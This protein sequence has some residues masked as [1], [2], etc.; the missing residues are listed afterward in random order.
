MAS[1]KTLYLITARG[2]SKGLPG[3]N[4]KEL[5]GKPLVAWSIEQAQNSRFA[6]DVIVSTDSEEI[7]EICREYGAEVPFLRP[8]QLASDEASSIDVVL[9]AIEFLEGIGR[10]YDLIGL[11]EPTSPLRDSE[12]LDKATEL[13]LLTEG[14]E[15]V[16]SV[17]LAKA[18][19][20]HYLLEMDSQEFLSFDDNFQLKRRQ[21]LND[22][23]FFEGC[24]YISYIESIKKRKSFFHS[25]TIGYEVSSLKAMEIDDH[26][27]F[28]AI[29]RLMKAKIDG[30][31]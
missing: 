15:S 18:V 24:L 31:I 21:E 27:E 3:K 2:G 23:Y 11:I 29:E 12:D 16:V 30:E 14:A 28:I 17:C 4:K 10:K 25:K 9:H 6:A 8:E 1:H 20:P 7:A 26:A 5:L 13:L 22:V 19:H